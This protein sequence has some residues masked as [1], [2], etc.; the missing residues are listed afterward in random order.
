LADAVEIMVFEVNVAEEKPSHCVLADDV[1]MS[2]S[3]VVGSMT[4]WSVL[5]NARRQFVVG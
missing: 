5:T 2:K 1:E 4:G 3:S